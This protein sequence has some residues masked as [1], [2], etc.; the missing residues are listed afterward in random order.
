[1]MKSKVGSKT[2]VRAI[3]EGLYVGAQ[4]TMSFGLGDGSFGGRAGGVGRGMKASN[5]GAETM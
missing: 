1:M 3:V 4:S 2:R 5:D